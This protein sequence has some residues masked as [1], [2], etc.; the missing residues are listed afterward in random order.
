MSCCAG[1]VDVE[2]DKRCGDDLSDLPRAQADVAECLEGHLEQGV[3]AFADGSHAVVGLVELLL[4]RGEPAG[5]GVLERHGDGAGFAFV[6]QVAERTQVTSGGGEGGQ[7]LGVGA[8]PRWCHAR[9]RAARRR[10]R[11]ASRPAR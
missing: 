4:D 1:V 3:A 11:S 8:Q 9:G 10:S 5:L 7:D 6:A 2:Q